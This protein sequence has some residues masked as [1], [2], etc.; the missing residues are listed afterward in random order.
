MR[1][2]E[3]ILIGIDSFKPQDGNWLHLEELL[4]EL[5]ATE[6]PEIGLDNL[7]GLLER[8]AEED[9]IGVFWSVVHGIEQMNDYEQSLLNSLNRR[10][11]IVTVLMVHRIANTGQI[12]ILDKEIKAIYRELLIDSKVLPSIRE[13]INRYLKRMD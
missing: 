5:W 13:R 12:M 3:E 4:A 1:K 7:F 10:P 6:K 2:I 8:Y 9:G 11:S